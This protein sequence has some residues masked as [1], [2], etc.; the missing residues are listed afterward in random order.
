MHRIRPVTADDDWVRMP[1]AADVIPWICTRCGA[2][3]T[4][5]PPMRELGGLKPREVHA[6]WH[7][8]TDQTGK[9]QP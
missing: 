3:V 9:D 4:E 1:L 6:R 7:A 5:G 8:R 2:T